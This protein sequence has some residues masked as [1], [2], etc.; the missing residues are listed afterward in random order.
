MDIFDYAMQM[1]KEGEKYYRELAENCPDPGHKELL[2]MMADQEVRHFETFKAMKENDSVEFDEGP[3]REN[4][5]SVFQK[6]AE[7]G[8]PLDSAE[9]IVDFYRRAQELE[10][11]AREFYTSQAEQAGS[12]AAKQ[13]L[14]K[15]A[16][17]ERAHYQ[18]LGTMIEFASRPAQGQW[19]ENAEWYNPSAS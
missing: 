2:T 12:E 13:T 19:L 17:E 7:S 16:E 11:E 4:A 18:M 1:E 10:K 6:M 9:S 5:K 3:F 8:K 15:I 14:L